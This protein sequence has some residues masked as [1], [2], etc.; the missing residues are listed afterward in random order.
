MFS[1]VA[2]NNNL[3]VVGRQDGT[4]TVLSLQEAHKAVR[5]QLTG[6]DWDGIRDMAFNGKWIFAGCRDATVRKYDFNQILVHYK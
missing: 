2:L 5:V 4:C 6:S 3:F 1:L